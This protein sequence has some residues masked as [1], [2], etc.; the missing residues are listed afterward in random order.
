M[1]PKVKD[2][3]V[4]F[5]ERVKII[6]FPYEFTGKNQKDNIEKTWL[7][8]PQELSGIFNWILTGQHRLQSQGD[9][10]DSKNTKE[11]IT[12]FKR[13]SDTIGAWLD[14]N[15]IFDKDSFETRQALYEDYKQ[16]TDDLGMAPETDKRFYQRLRETP[17]IK[18]HKTTNRGFKGIKLKL[19]TDSND[20]ENSQQTLTTQTNENTAHSADTAPFHSFSNTISSDNILSNNHQIHA[21]SAVS[22]VKDKEL[23][24][25]EINNHVCGDC[26]RFHTGGCQHPM[27]AMGGDPELM[28]ADSAWAC[29]C[30]GY[31][32]KQPE[33]P[34]YPEEAPIIES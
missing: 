7:E 23:Q 9:F 10:T 20:N 18:D 5:W 25:S 27:L 26:G 8:D 30:Q 11:T 16:Y 3:S 13:A 2:T 28:K 17:K 19:N 22:A 34:S 33:M 32:P 24:Q 1:F 31:I 12:E 15:C 29:S 4:G 14:T 21:V 6:K